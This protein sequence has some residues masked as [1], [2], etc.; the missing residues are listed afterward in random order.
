[1]ER[2]H[3]KLFRHIEPDKIITYVC[4]T[5]LIIGWN[6]FNCTNLLGVMSM[7][8]TNVMGS[9]R[10]STTQILL[11]P[12]DVNE[13]QQDIF[14]N[15]SDDVSSNTDFVASNTADVQLIA[16]W[17]YYCWNSSDSYEVCTWRNRLRII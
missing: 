3:K 7:E 10:S 15:E 6:R 13:N 11:D 5:T 1:M 12:W 14:A 9:E 2:S 17:Q 4:Y 8:S 16:G